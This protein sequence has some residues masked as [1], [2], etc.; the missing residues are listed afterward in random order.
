MGQC[1]FLS[2]TSNKTGVSEAVLHQW[3]RQIC[4]SSACALDVRN[5]C[6]TQRDP[7]TPGSERLL[8]HLTHTHTY[9]HPVAFKPEAVLQICKCYVSHFLK[10]GTDISNSIS[11]V[12]SNLWELLSMDGIFKEL[13]ANPVFAVSDSY[14]RHVSF[15]VH[16]VE[17]KISFECKGFCSGKKW[18]KV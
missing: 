1:N 11:H 6:L 17:T 18:M 3:S 9:P 4:C 5:D 15:G 10:M 8:T 7:R 14:T 12:I 2:S 13:E 16:N